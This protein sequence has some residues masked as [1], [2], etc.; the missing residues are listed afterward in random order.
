MRSWIQPGAIVRLDPIGDEPQ[1]RLARV[2]EVHDI[3]SLVLIGAVKGKTGH[4]LV[5]ES[6]IDVP[7]KPPTVRPD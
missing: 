5:H 3:T 1:G 6:I 4:A 2:Y 7:V